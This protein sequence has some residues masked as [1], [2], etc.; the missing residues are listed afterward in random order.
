MKT[1]GRGERAS[2][3][4]TRRRLERWRG[5]HGGPGKRIPE[6]LWGEAVEVARV[7]G[8]APTAKALRLDPR[9]LRRRVAASGEEAPQREPDGP[10]GSRGSSGPEFV[11]LDA[12]GL[13]GPKQTV[14]RVDEGEGRRLVVEVSGETTVDVAAVVEA[15]GR[16]TK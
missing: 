5:R 10:S 13:F 14:V 7:Q 6:E 11:E 12:R 8:V 3:S 15:F 2:L 9:G 4:E 1:A 16:G